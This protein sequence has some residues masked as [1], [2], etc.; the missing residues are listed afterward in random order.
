MSDKFDHIIR[1]HVDRHEYDIDPQDIWNGIN[2]KSK[3]DKVGFWVWPVGLAVLLLVSYSL[4]AVFSEDEALT[5]YSYSELSASDKTP[6]ITKSLDS[7]LIEKQNP[8]STKDRISPLVSQKEEVKD[9]SVRKT[10]TQ[11]QTPSYS[12]QLEHNRAIVNPLGKNM[13][14]SNDSN[15]ELEKRI[16]KST[17]QSNFLVKQSLQSTSVN[18]IYLNSLNYLEPKGSH[19]LYDRDQTFDFNF[20]ELA[21]IIKPTYSKL[22]FSLSAGLSTVNRDLGAS[23]PD[24]INLIESS[25]EPY[26]TRHN[27]FLIHYGLTNNFRISTGVSHQKIVTL[28][29]WTG[30]LLRDNQGVVIGHFNEADGLPAGFTELFYESIDRRIRQYNGATLVDLPVNLEYAFADYKLRP[31]LSIGAAFNVYNS[32]EGYRLDAEGLPQYLADIEDKAQIGIRYSASLSLH[33]P[34]TPSI[35]IFGDVGG[36]M[37]TIESQDLSTKYQ[38]LDFGVGLKYKL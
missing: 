21:P 11:N 36:S 9:K 32:V 31:I 1:D 38:W 28:F 29:D 35:A 10:A 6:L 16:I 37:R 20:A 30:V 24:I 13:A 27:D 18:A 3:K 33:Y 17:R 12:K 34:L 15:I 25:E 8:T 23:D 19:L 14:E 2:K 7:P 22:A 5:N 4:H 26:S